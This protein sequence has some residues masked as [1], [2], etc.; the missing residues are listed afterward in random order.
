MT[1]WNFPNN[2]IFSPIIR[3]TSAAVDVAAP[4]YGSAPSLVWSEPDWLTMPTPP[5]H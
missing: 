5:R 3:P 4:E 2:D 1:H